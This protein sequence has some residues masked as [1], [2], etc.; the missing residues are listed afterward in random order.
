MI[1]GLRIILI[2]EDNMVIES[3]TVDKHMELSFKFSLEFLPYPL[4]TYT[5]F[6]LRSCDNS[7]AKTQDFFEDMSSRKYCIIGTR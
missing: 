7:K 2:I 1:H 3:Y 4:R 6:D 5:F